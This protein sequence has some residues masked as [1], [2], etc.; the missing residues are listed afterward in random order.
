MYSEK[1]IKN[2]IRN[3]IQSVTNYIQK[4]H[5]ECPIIHYEDIYK[6]QCFLQDKLE[7]H[8]K[9]INLI[10][11]PDKYFL[12]IIVNSKELSQNNKQ[13]VVKIVTI[14]M[15]N[16]YIKTVLKYGKDYHKSIEAILHEVS[17]GYFLNNLRLSGNINFMYVYTPFY[18]SVGKDICLNTKIENL[19]TCA[20]FEYVDGISVA[21]YMKNNCDNNIT[22]LNT[23]YIK[24][25][26]QLVLALADAQ[27]FCNFV[28]Y[29][30][31]DENIMLKK[32]KTPV[33]MV[34]KHIGYK[35][36]NVDFYP[37]IIDYGNAI[38]KSNNN[39]FL[40]FTHSTV[41]IKY[42]EDL[43][44]NKDP[45]LSC[46]DIFHFSMM[47]L[48]TISR[49]EKEKKEDIQKIWKIIMSFFIVRAESLD[50]SVSC[51]KYLT[52]QTF[53][54]DAL[55]YRLK[56]KDKELVNIDIKHYLNYLIKI[57]NPDNLEIIV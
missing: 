31:H 29:D 26:L 18:C 34:Y 15:N 39:Y 6:I 48:Y 45:F 56:V 53:T 17:I 7:E 44:Y 23:T 46:Y 50:I 35:L 21:Q 20:F 4:T 22:I 13:G 51:K 25:F 43:S 8:N 5:E 38:V 12:D 19:T 37:C 11:S 42:F 49:C 3:Q 30:L 52:K 54:S 24:I 36:S 9:T 57:I 28:H 40:P 33:N 47:S 10:S 16:K 1:D 2:N 27:S 32:I 14:N 55:F 41:K